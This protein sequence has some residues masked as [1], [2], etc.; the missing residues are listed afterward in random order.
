MTIRNNELNTSQLIQF[1]R[2]H[3]SRE[4]KRFCENAT[5]FN[6]YRLNSDKGGIS[7]ALNM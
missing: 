1:V 2:S 5:V 7:T 3:Y 6:A 4:Q